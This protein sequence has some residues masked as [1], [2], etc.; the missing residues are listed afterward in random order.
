[1]NKEINEKKKPSSS[2]SELC[3]P[4]YVACEH[5]NDLRNDFEQYLSESFVQQT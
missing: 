3:I 5:L 2:S 4:I 1:M